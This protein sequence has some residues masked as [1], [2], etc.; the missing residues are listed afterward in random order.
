M[1]YSNKARHHLL[2]A[3]DSTTSIMEPNYYDTDFP[4]Y[5]EPTYR[6][7]KVNEGCYIKDREHQAD[8]CERWRPSVR[9]DIASKNY[10]TN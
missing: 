4:P 3:V 1:G 10:P 2:N 7:S 6:K 9:Q 8:Y 5:P